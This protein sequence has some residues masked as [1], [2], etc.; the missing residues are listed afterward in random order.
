M[1]SLA[2]TSELLL[3][4]LFSLEMAVLCFSRSLA[5]ISR[6]SGEVAA[7]FPLE[8][9]LGFRVCSLRLSNGLY[10]IA[11]STGVK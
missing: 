10:L 11:G 4:V 6:V 9:S 3:F 5:A 2:N 1:L 8:G 7:S